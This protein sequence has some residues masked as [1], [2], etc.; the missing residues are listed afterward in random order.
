MAPTCGRWRR[1]RAGARWLVPLALCLGVGCSTTPRVTGAAAAPLPPANAERVAERF[2][3]AASLLA[4]LEA[5]DEPGRWRTG[6]RLLIGLTFEDGGSVTERMLLVELTENPGRRAHY[7]RRVDV[8]GEDVRIDSPTREVILGLYDAEGR[9]LAEQ[10]GQLAEIFL[11]HGPVEVARIGGG[12]AIAT[13]AADEPRESPRPEITLEALTPSVYGMMSLLAFGDGASDNPTL[14]RLI[15]QAFT[16]GQ[17]FRLLWT[18]GRFEIRFGE[19][20]PL[21]PGSRPVPGLRV[22]EGYDC[23]IRVSIGGVEALSGRAV[24]APPHAPLGLGGGILRA[25]LVNS[26]APSIRIGL[27]LL[28]AARGEDPTDSGR[29]AG[30][31]PNMK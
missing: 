27:V 7:R 26:A 2:S 17:Q 3:G 25:E 6:D 23:E 21:S 1:A 28:G 30:I 31:V 18:W 11:D 13:G 19:V 9:L 12:F 22:E 4:G 29:I 5:A 14:A 8:F 24:V 15:R 20:S 16:T 10:P